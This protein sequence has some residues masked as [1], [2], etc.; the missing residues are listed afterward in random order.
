MN[1]LDTEYQRIT[2]VAK[3]LKVAERN[4]VAAAAGISASLILKMGNGSHTNPSIRV[5]SALHDAMVSLGFLAA[6][7]PEHDM[8]MINVPIPADEAPAKRSLARREYL[9]PGAATFCC[10]PLGG[11]R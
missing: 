4:T 11:N 10:S 6:T 7:T 1:T 2:D 3:T 5:L 8:T 9:S